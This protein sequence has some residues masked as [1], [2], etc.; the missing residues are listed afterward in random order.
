MQLL[1]TILGGAVGAAIVTGVFAVIK[2]KMERKAAKEDK[3]DD[4][5]DAIKKLDNKVDEA[6]ITQSKNS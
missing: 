3:H 2:F 6:Q 4:V 5:L 1:T